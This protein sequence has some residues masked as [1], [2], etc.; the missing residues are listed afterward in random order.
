MDTKKVINN[1]NLPI[2]FPVL[3]TV[4][5]A[6]ALDYWGAPQWV[7]GAVGLLTVIA[8]VGAIIVKVKEEEQEDIFKTPPKTATKS[9]FEEK[10]KQAMDAGDQIKSKNQ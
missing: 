5:Y 4:V 10:L 8:W 6:T 7:W 3:A 1:K 2:K 9:K